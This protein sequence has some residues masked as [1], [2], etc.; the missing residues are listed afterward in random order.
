[1]HNIRGLL[2]ALFLSLTLAVSAA[3][4]PA[5]SAASAIL[6]DGASGRV[7]YEDNAQEER[8]IASITKIMTALVAIESTP[9]LDELVTI[10]REYT[11]TE[12]SSIYLKEGEQLTLEELLYG[13][14]LN[15]GNDA[16]LAIAGHCA[17]DTQTFVDWMNQRARSLGM[18]HTHF[19]NPNGLNDEDHYSSAEDMALL[20]CEA[21]KN[22]TFAQ[23]VATKSITFGERSF[24]NHNK[25]LWQYEQTVGVKTG[26]TQMA[27]RTLVSCAERDGQ[28]LIVVTLHDP[29]DWND[30]IALLEYGFSQYPQR[31]LCRAGKGMCQ[32]PVEGGVTELVGVETASYVGYPLSSEERVQARITLP[33]TVTAPVTAG[34]VAGEIQFFLDGEVIGRSYLVFSG[35]VPVQRRPGVLDWLKRF[36]GMEEQATF[37]RM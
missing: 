12:G 37:L 6:V 19:S 1:M 30:H 7:L 11:L 17:G 3:A 14:M 16:A 9:D 4:A 32:L 2:I 24:Q 22:P 26:Y 27:G 13:L 21:M 31:M 29:D 28:R 34:A 18:E 35:D 25:L 5:T 10:K 8:L 33:Q 23:I 36:W 20:T 15:S